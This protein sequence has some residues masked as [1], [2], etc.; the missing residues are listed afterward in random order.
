[1][2]E[3]M[4]LAGFAGAAAWDINNAGLMV[5]NSHV[6]GSGNGVAVYYISPNAP[7]NIND[8][9]RDTA[10]D[11]SLAGWFFNVAAGFP[12]PTPRP[13]RSTCRGWLLRGRRQSR[14]RLAH[15]SGHDSGH[16]QNHQRGPA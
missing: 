11:P 15:G 14:D 6:S 13:A 9:E 3:F 10:A 1:M 2:A 4:P 16:L 7:V 5:G 12:T 8:L